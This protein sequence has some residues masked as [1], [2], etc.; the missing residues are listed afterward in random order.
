[1]IGST[2][3]AFRF[4]GED[5]HDARACTYTYTYTLRQNG[6]AAAIDAQLCGR[7]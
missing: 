3:R 5:A 4:G 7:Q 1:M 2:G 6:L